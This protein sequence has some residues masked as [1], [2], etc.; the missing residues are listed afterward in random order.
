MSTRRR[1]RDAGAG[2]GAQS[3]ATLLALGAM[4]LLVAELGPEGFG[5]LS[6]NLGLLN[7]AAVGDL[8]VGRA[9][10]KYVAGA[11]RSQTDRYFRVGAALTLAFSIPAALGLWAAAGPLGR[12]VAGNEVSQAAT[13]DTIAAFELTAWGLPAVL[14]RILLVGLLVGKGRVG[15]LSWMSALADTVK[16]A[17][18]VGAALSFGS[19]AAV[20]GAYAAAAYLHAA[21][22]A[23]G[24]FGGAEPLAAVRIGWDRQVVRQLLRLG[25]WGTASTLLRQAL[26]QSDRWL[27]GW[28]TSLE[29]VGYYS[30]ARELAARLAYVPHH[31]CRAYFA[32]FG[33]LYAS[34]RPA[35]ARAYHQARTLTAAATV[36][37]AAGLAL[38]AE[39]LLRAWIDPLTAAHAAGLLQL[40]APA[41]LADALGQVPATAI[42]AGAGEPRITALLWGAALGGYLALGAAGSAWFAWASPETSAAGLAVG[43]AISCAAASG[44]AALWIERRLGGAASSARGLALLLGAVMAAAAVA[45][46]IRLLAGPYLD[47]LI[48]TL[49]A[50]ALAYALYLAVLAGAG[51]L[52]GGFAGAP[53]WGAEAGHEHGASR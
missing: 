29:I 12:M 14:V 16:I 27:L 28:L 37:L 8:G 6:L 51:L 25:S 44:G 52:L 48:A 41:Y 22:L 34:D 13:A 39:P 23:R 17:L 53:V 45:L 21:L 38:F 2:L 47:G 11:D 50:M 26:L 7:L 32:V 20:V 35:A 5:V 15:A 24:C 43:L 49:A 36:G 19:P 40:L 1:L 10:S 18:G 46:P 31:V 4:P 33:R 42:L 30:V 9:M 3:W